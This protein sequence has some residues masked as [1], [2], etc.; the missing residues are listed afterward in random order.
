MT[1][2]AFYIKS[3]FIVFFFLNISA[4]AQSNCNCQLYLDLLAAGKPKLEIYSQVVKQNTPI[5]QAKAAELI[6]EISMLNIDNLDSSEIYLKNAAS[7]FNKMACGEGVLMNTYKNF[8][9]LYWSKSDYPKAQNYAL[10]YLQSAELQKDSYHQALANTM[11]AITFYKTNQFEKGL[12][13]ANKATEFLPYIKDEKNKQKLLY[14]LAARFITH[15]LNTNSTSS[16]EKSLNYNLQHLALSKKLKD[17]IEFSRSYFNLSGTAEANNNWNLADAYLDSGYFFIDRT[18]TID[19]YDYHVN[20]AS[21]YLELKNYKKANLYG[22]SALYYVLKTAHQTDIAV[23]YNLL[24]TIAQEIGDFKN[25]LRY[26]KLSNAINDSISNIVKTKAVV[27]LEKKYNQAK[28]ENLIKDLGNKQQLFLLLAIAGLFAAISIGFFLRQQSLKHKKDI[29]ETEQ[30]LNR[31]RINPHFFFNTLT[32]LQKIVLFDNDKQI[33]A[34]QLSKFGNIMRETLESTYKDYITIEE[35]IEFLTEYFDLQK[36]RFPNSF[37]FDFII[38]QTLEI[39]EVLLPAMILQPFVENSIEHGFAGINYP[40]KITI[41]FWE[42]QNNLLVE[43]RDNGNGLNTK[44]KGENEHI[45]RA[46]QIIKDRLYLLNLKLKT[47]AGFSIENNDKG[48]VI[49]K[50]NLPLLY[51]ES[52]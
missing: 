12:G 42:D 40:G 31:A 37:N 5:C 23:C 1:W 15:Y 43:I 33:L 17:T 35:E 44:I 32:T 26:Y 30:R 14:L 39:N 9:Q 10:K 50:I 28:N 51:K 29:L 21:L 46:S 45:S 18:D 36:V 2:S 52:I 20:K 16:I 13:F 6:A 7:L 3:L 38:P 11:I 27:E 47:K 22:D 24:A 48:G 49:V 19:L 34:R 4:G 41:R 8:F 25:A